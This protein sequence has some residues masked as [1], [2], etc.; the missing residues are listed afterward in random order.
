MI[1][2]LANFSLLKIRSGM[3]FP[4][5]G[6]VNKRQSSTYFFYFLP[7]IIGKFPYLNVSKEMIR[8]TFGHLSVCI[9]L[10]GSLAGCAGLAGKGVTHRVPEAEAKLLEANM[11]LDAVNAQSSEYYA[12]LGPLLQQI[13]N[14]R[15]QPGWSQFE[16]ILLEFP[17]LRDPDNEVEITPELESRFSEWSRRWKTSWEDTMEGYRYLVDKCIIMEA[18][19]LAARERLL[20]EQARYIFVA[21]SEWKAGRYKEGNEIYSVVDMLDKSAAELNSYQVDELGLYGGEQ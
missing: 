18:K 13:K 2:N 6:T 20:A 3:Y 10:I 11:A 7:T 14:F 9:F 12:Q 8:K 15:A 17:V 21:A 16:Q 5:T 4:C 1:S 19:R